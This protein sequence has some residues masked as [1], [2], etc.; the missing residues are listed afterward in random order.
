[1]SSVLMY[2]LNLYPIEEIQKVTSGNSPIRLWI[3]NG[4]ITGFTNDDDKILY[5]EIPTQTANPSGDK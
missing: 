1:M 5:K 2:M 4:R 3:E